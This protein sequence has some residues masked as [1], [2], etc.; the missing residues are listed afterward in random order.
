MLD[1]PSVLK[2]MNELHLREADDIN[3]DLMKTIVVPKNY[4]FLSETLPP[5]NYD[6]LKLVQIEKGRFLKT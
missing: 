2:R 6:P 5:P 4:S 1:M 3:P